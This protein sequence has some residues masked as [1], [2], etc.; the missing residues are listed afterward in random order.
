MYLHVSHIEKNRNLFSSAIHVSLLQSS[1]KGPLVKTSD[2][3]QTN[4]T[5]EPG[6]NSR[7]QGNTENPTGSS[8]FEGQPSKTR[9]KFLSKQGAPFGFVRYDFFEPSS[10]FANGFGQILPMDLDESAPLTQ[11]DSGK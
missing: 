5:C 7:S 3:L 9:P 8:T 11:D 10:R 1:N 6:L 2:D 4:P